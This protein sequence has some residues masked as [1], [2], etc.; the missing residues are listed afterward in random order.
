MGPYKIVNNF[1]EASGENLL[2]GGGEATKT[3]TDI[4]IRHN[5]LFK[6]LTWMP[7]APG[8][9]G[10]EDGHP[11]IV[12]NL[13][14]LKNAQRLLFEGN[15]LEGSWGGFSQTG[16]AIL[17]TPK[18]QNDSCPLCRVNDVTIRYCKISHVASG[19]WIGNSASDAGGLS[20][21]G[22]RYSIHDVIIDDI[23]GKKYSGYGSFL[24]LISN[25]PTLKDVKMDHITALSSRVFMN[26]GIKNH[27]IQ[28]FTFTNN[29]IAAD[30][31]QISTTGGGQA[32]CAF[33]PEKLGPAGV[34]DNC[35]ESLTFSHNAIICGFGSWPPGN[36]FP[37]NVK[38]AGLVNGSDLDKF[39]LCKGKEAGCDG[40]SKYAA[41]GTDGKNIG[42]DID[43]LEA[44]IRGAT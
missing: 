42:A 40:P 12:K 28:N 19:F 38:A 4:E 18:N 35:V 21:G 41:A 37:K 15:V 31:K 13:F 2:F 7:G 39:R 26:V 34:L 27:K 20:S 43:R 16:L 30:E 6:P 22:E 3:P 29:L 17:L 36:F 1:L 44:A 32:N 10:G 33:H 9:V 11:F 23:D 5:H 8:F 25:D 14:E 24:I